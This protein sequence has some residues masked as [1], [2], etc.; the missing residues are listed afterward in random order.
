[1]LLLWVWHVVYGGRTPVHALLWRC[2]CPVLSLEQ[3]WE[4]LL[5]LHSVPCVKAAWSL[6]VVFLVDILMSSSSRPRNISVTV[7]EPRC[8]S[9]GPP[10][11]RNSPAHSA[12]LLHFPLSLSPVQRPGW[13]YSQAGAGEWSVQIMGSWGHCCTEQPGS[14][15][16]WLSVCLWD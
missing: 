2:H 5:C 12:V 13:G 15:C 1:M 9:S 4:S 10:T 16:K 3:R 14:L 8:G 7:F 11:Q 6:V